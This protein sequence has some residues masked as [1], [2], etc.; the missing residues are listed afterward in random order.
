MNH[1]FTREQLAFLRE[2]AAGCGSDELTARINARF[3]LKLSLS[4]IRACKKNHGIK[5]GIDSR[6]YPGYAAHNKGKSGRL[7]GSLHN[8]RKAIARTITCPS[9][10]NA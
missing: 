10:L 4:Q 6:F 8:T 1:Q 2:N 5:S 9:D 3:G 7:D